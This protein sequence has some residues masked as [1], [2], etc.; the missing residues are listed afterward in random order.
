MVN[1]ASLDAVRDL[2]RGILAKNFA[3]WSVIHPV[4]WVKTVRRLP[5]EYGATLPFDF[6]Y[7]PYEKEMFEECFNVRN[8]EVEIGRA[9]V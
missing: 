1:L 6:G 2:A 3:T 4:E 9:H 8:Q 5:G 7:A